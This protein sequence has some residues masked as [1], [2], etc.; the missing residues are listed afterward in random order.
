MFFVT[1][2]LAMLEL[3]MITPFKLIGY[4]L[5]QII[6]QD[7]KLYKPQKLQILKFFELDELILN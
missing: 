1:V 3:L 4:E 6:I 7:I 2:V 5:T